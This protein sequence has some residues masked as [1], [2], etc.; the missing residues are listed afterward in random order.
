MWDNENLTDKAFTDL[1]FDHTESNFTTKGSYGECLPYYYKDKIILFFTE[2]QNSKPVIKVNDSLISVKS[3][4]NQFYIIENIEGEHFIKNRH[5]EFE[6]RFNNNQ[7]FRNN[8][9]AA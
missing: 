5:G 8:N 6:L 7:D 4:N 9:Y 2:T 1:K 3:L